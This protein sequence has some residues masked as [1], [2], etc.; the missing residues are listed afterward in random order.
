MTPK[1]KRGRKKLTVS[2]ELSFKLNQDFKKANYVRSAVSPPIA[3]GTVPVKRL[4]SIWKKLIFERPEML[5]LMVPVSSLSFKSICRRLESKY[6]SSGMGPCKRLKFKSIC[7]RERISPSLLGMVPV[8][9]PSS[10]IRFL[11]VW[12]RL[13]SDGSVPATPFCS[14]RENDYEIVEHKR[15]MT[16]CLANKMIHEN[17]I[18]YFR[19]PLLNAHTQFDSSN[20]VVFVTSQST[21][22]A[23]VATCQP[24]VGVGLKSRYLEVACGVR[25]SLR[26]CLFFLGS[27]LVQQWWSRA[28]RPSISASTKIKDAHNISLNQEFVL[29][30]KLHGVFVDD[31]FQCQLLWRS[32]SVNISRI[33][34]NSQKDVDQCRSTLNCEV[35]RANGNWSRSWSHRARG[36]YRW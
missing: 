6:S 26:L 1:E 17:T 11:R 13:S 18:L 28:F 12:R 36:F 3:S 34:D 20:K 8:R 19:N 16:K 30:T 35:A 29:W 23:F 5:E 4:F 31:P 2:Q 9:M 14:R 24:G 25:R 15:E 22:S 7:S 33:R 10:R 32:R 27:V 21:P